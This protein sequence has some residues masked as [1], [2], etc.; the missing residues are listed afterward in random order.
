MTKKKSKSGRLVIK[1]DG[2]LVLDAAGRGYLIPSS[3]EQTNLFLMALLDTLGEPDNR[4]LNL[5]LAE[6]I[7][8]I[9]EEE[10]DGTSI[11]ETASPEA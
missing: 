5:Y 7:N 1:R 6:K 11:Q 3:N 4:M 10:T 8:R 9:K 2:A